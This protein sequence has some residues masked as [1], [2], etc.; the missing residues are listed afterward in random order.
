MSK[1]TADSKD[2]I[3]FAMGKH[4]LENG[5]YLGKSNSEKG[6]YWSCYHF[7]S[8]Y[9]ISLDDE[10]GQFWPADQEDIDSYNQKPV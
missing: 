1:F 10:P 8:D 2:K 3:P 4:I 9:F 6:S 5:E 7:G